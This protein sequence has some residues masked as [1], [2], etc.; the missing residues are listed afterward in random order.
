MKPPSDALD[1]SKLRE[2]D[3][4]LAEHVIYYSWQALKKIPTE[5]ELRSFGCSGDITPQKKRR[6]FEEE[7]RTKQAKIELRW[8]VAEAKQSQRSTRAMWE[9]SAGVLLFSRIKPKQ[10]VY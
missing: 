2:S 4:Q 9:E 7:H 3:P 6:R 10:F 1:S 5:P 8:T